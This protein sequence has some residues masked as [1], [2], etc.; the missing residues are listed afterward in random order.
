MTTTPTNAKDTA[1]R[2]VIIEGHEFEV[3]AGVPDEAIRATLALDFPFVAAA[4][5]KHGAKTRDGVAY[6]TIEFV[7]RVGVKGAG[8]AG[9]LVARLRRAPGLDLADTAQQ[10][11]D[12]RLFRRLTGGELTVDQA[13]ALDWEAIEIS[14]DRTIPEGGELCRRIMELE[15]VAGDGAIAGWSR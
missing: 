8:G 3:E 15:A 6:A 1:T 7:K 4:E 12:R 9:D 13:L 5:V 14:L 10:Q 11:V 2:L